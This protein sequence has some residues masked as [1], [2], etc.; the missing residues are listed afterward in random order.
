MIALLLCVAAFAGS[1]WAGRRSLGLGLV[2]ILTVGYFYGIL[3][4]NLL[5]TFSH[6]IF[7][8]G[9][10]GLYLSQKW[11]FSNPTESRRLEVAQLWLIVLIAWPI[12]MVAMPFQPLLV[13]LVGLRGHI[14]FLPIF[15]LGSRL[16]NQDLLE[17]S[18]GL[19]VLNL[20]ALVFAGMEYF[21]SVAQFYPFSAVTQIIYASGDIA[22]GYLRIPAIFTSAHAYG[23]MMVGSLPYLIGGWDRADSNTSRLLAMLGIGAA[24]LGVLLSATRSNF[25]QA[26]VMVIVTILTTRVTAKSRILFL[27]LIAGL[28]VTAM[29]NVRFQRFKSLSD[30][31][32]V[33]GRIAGSVN[34]GFWEILVEHPMG[35]GLGGGG[36]SI[37]YFLEGQVRN[38]IGMENG[39]ALILCEQGLMGLL[40][41]IGFIGWFLSHV[42]AAFKKGAWANSRRL[43]WC[44]AAFCLATAWIGIGMFTSIPATVILLLGMGWTAIPSAEGSPS[45][46]PKMRNLEQPRFAL[47]YTNLF[48]HRDQKCVS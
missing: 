24:L 36:T 13:S 38:P 11:S 16:R 25:I 8:A 21:T 39:Y 26:S 30:S 10:V 37:P 19:A 33:V 23:G 47:A 48:R 2:A 17:L 35:N 34:R 22:G 7:D 43:A 29:T 46:E 4:A 45:R 31:D 18:V 28:G 42:G 32:A 15:L 41:W 40:L 12:L 27:L 44:Y 6:F 1:Y 9:L 3:R 14:F 20:V 5:T